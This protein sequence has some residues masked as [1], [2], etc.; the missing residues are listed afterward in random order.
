MPNPS[1]TP[2]PATQEDHWTIRHS[3]LF[4]RLPD[5][6]FRTLFEGKPVHVAG[7]AMPLFAWGTPAR[8]CFIVL[9]GLVK[10]FRTSETG[11]AAVL[12]ICGPCRPLML[13]EGLTAKPYSASAETVSP[14]RIMCLDV[15]GLRQSMAENSKLS[16]AL[17]AAAASDLRSLVAHVEELKAMT[18]PARLAAMILNLS[19]ARAGAMQITLPYEKQLIAGRLGMTPE[20]FSRAM[21]Q[22]KD[23]GVKV[24]RDRLVIT[25]IERLRGF[26]NTRV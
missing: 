1:L 7:K 11:E 14:V 23:Q 19:E 6:T 4:G 3:S 24:S 5:T 25:D 9:K 20:S 12:S 18:G 21:R 10:L 2:M 13:A 15:A 26:L 8:T 17:L 22:L 16:M